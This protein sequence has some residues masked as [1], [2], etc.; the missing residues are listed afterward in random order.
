[1]DASYADTKYVDGSYTS[2]GTALYGDNE[3]YEVPVTIQ[4]KDGKI[5]NVAYLKD[6]RSIIVN[7]D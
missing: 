7:S 1:M 6:I 3:T 5:V 4:I 2:V